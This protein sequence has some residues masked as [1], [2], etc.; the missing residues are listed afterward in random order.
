MDLEVIKYLYWNGNY[1]FIINADNSFYES[2][3]YSTK[4][5]PTIYLFKQNWFNL[6]IKTSYYSHS[7]IWPSFS[8]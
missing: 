4:K 6:N 3:F 1:L 7:Y 8:K 2:D 5:H